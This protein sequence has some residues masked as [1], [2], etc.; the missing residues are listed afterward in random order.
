MQVIVNDEDTVRQTFLREITAFNLLE[1]DSDRSFAVAATSF[2]TRRTPGRRILP[3][4]FYKAIAAGNK[5][6]FNRA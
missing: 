6:R 3:L 1:E 4:P 5:T 2:E